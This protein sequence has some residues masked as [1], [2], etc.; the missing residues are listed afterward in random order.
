MDVRAGSEKDEEDTKHLLK[1]K[2]VRRLW[3]AIIVHVLKGSHIKKKKEELN[4][5][6]SLFFF[7]ITNLHDAHCLS[8]VAFNSGQKAH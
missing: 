7:K 8:N 5:K 4:F 3:R 6:M 2:K 1:A